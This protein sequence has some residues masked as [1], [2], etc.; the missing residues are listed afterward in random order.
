MSGS[1]K[2]ASMLAAAAEASAGDGATVSKDD[3]VEDDDADDAPSALEV[4]AYSAFERATTPKDKAHALKL[5]IR[6]CR[7][8]G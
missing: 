6:A 7:A 8:G 5:F 3:E 1:G 4:R 2:V